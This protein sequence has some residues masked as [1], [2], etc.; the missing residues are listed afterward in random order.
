MWKNE[1]AKLNEVSVY[2]VNNFSS[3]ELLLN[4]VYDA[5][6]GLNKTFSS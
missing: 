3:F 2:I 4:Q 6:V 1:E 5:R